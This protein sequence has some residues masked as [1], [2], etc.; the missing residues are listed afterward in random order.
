LQSTLLRFAIA[1][2]FRNKTGTAEPL[3]RDF[4]DN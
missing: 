1:A 3:L 4:G 2:G